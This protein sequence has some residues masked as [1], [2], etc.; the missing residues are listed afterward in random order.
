MWIK[1][2]LTYYKRRWRLI[3]WLDVAG[4]AFG[5]F[6]LAFFTLLFAAA[7]HLGM[8]QKAVI[9]LSICSALLYRLPPH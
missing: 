2:K 9:A 5:Y 6:V 4:I 3:D 8:H 7:L 1:K